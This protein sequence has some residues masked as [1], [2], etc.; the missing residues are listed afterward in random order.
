MKHTHIGLMAIILGIALTGNAA[1]H[2]DSDA[3][4]KPQPAAASTQPA[5]SVV[6]LPRQQFNIELLKYM[7]RQGASIADIERGIYII[8]G[9]RVVADEG[10]VEK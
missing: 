6:V 1:T 7:L 2:D 9:K 8:D 5:D 4:S 3:T 10:K